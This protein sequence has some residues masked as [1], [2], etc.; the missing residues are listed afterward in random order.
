MGGTE[1]TEE[2]EEHDKAAVVPVTSSC[3]T[4]V[5]E[6]GSA[7]MSCSE[8]RAGNAEEVTEEEEDDDDDDKEGRSFGLEDN[9]ND[10]E[11]YAAAA[12]MSIGTEEEEGMN[13]LS[14]MSIYAGRGRLSSLPVA[15]VAA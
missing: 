9:E 15:A 1:R 11:Q 3:P 7:V 4:H 6:K 12:T 14:L 5:D 2:S 10:D 8:N 13:E